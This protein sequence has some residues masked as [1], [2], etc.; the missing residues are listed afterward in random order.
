MYVH[1]YANESEC[2]ARTS[3]PVAVSN[4]K[5]V[6]VSIVIIDFLLAATV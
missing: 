2:A 4:S 5:H 6:A 1:K 3:E